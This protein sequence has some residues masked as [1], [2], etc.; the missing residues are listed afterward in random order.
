MVTL[1]KLGDDDFDVLL[2]GTGEQE[3]LCLGIAREAQGLS[4]EQLANKAGFRQ[5]QI[6]RLEGGN[7]KP[8]PETKDKLADALGYPVDRIF[9][10]SGIQPSDLLE[11]WLDGRLTVERTTKARFRR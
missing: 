8:R 2:A 3:F 4:Q 10:P 7:R 5:T 11:A 9:P 6:S 1:V